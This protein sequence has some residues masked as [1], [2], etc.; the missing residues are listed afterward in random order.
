MRS[1]R[2][3]VYFFLVVLCMVIVPVL[4]QD[5]CPALVQSAIK[6]VGDLCAATGL[7]QACYGNLS[8]KAEAQA[9]VSSLV[10]D[11]P[12][13]VARV[14][15]LKTLRVDPFDD[16]KKEWGVAL[17]RLQAN[18]PDT[19]PGQSV[20][21]LVFGDVQLTN[22]V[23]STDSPSVTLTSNTVLLGDPQDSTSIVG[24][25]ASGDKVFALSQSADK[26][27]VRVELDGSDSRT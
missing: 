19:L 25:L 10:F 2:V 20:S 13:D 26:Q 16:V 18:I 27:W 11:K 6:A 8:L 14:A 21:F 12:G 5:D 3:I 17:M 23:A 9:D 1:L 7:N 22:K 15:N 24:G 4:A